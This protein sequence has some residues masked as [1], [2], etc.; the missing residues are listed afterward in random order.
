MDAPD[1][2]E[3]I[4][5]AARRL[6]QTAPGPHAVSVASVA[7]AACVSRATVYRYFPGRATLLAAAQSDGQYRPADARTQILEAALDV[8]IERGIRN[9]SLREVAKRAGLS[10]SGVHWYFRNKDELVAGVVE[11]M[12]LLPVIAAEAALAGTADLETQLSRIAEAAL[13][14]L[15]SRQGLIRMALAEFARYPEVASLAATHTIGRGLPLLARIFDEHEHRGELRPGASVVRAQAFM[16]MLVT[17]VLMRP[18]LGRLFPADN[19]ECAREY[20]QI[21]LRGVLAPESAAA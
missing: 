7:S 18:V 13:E 21:I 2:R 16:G 20:V 19:R 5:E 17:L 9:T 12:R 1:R 14:A 10:L 4:L 3:E 15:G 11:H 8:F 6:I